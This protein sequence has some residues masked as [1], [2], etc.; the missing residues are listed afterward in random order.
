MDQDD[1]RDAR[2][3]STQKTNQYEEGKLT[4][5]EPNHLPS[6]FLYLVHACA[7]SKKSSRT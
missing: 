6:D 4:S 7:K 5:V 1:L 2:M 3:L